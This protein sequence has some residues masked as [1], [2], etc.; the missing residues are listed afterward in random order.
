MVPLPTSV[1]LIFDGLFVHRPEF[2]PLW[3]LSVMLHA[4]R[5]CDETWLRFLE[6]DLPADPV[7]RA[8][9]VDRRLERARWPRYRHGWQKYI[10]SV[11]PAAATM[12]IDNEDLEAPAIIS[13]RTS[14]LP[15]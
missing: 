12:D 3:D 10:G 6:D 4:D 2:L 15:E 13:D 5:R 8:A 7:E 9:E 1:I 14:L 11:D